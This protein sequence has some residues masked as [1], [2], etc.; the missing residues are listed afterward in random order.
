MPAAPASSSATPNA[1]PATASGTRRWR[2]RRLRPT[3]AGLTAIVCVGESAGERAAGRALAVIGRQVERSTPETATSGNTA[4]AY[5]PVWAI[6]SGRAPGLA[7]IA[8]AHAEVRAAW[9][10]R[11]SGSGAPLRVL[12][13]GSVTA[14]NAG[15]HPGR[16]GRGRCAGRRR[17][18]VCG[19]VLADLPGVP[20]SPP[21][22]SR[23]ERRWKRSFSW[24]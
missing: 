13:G 20:L 2:P 14:R 12:Y 21:W 23:E 7:D 16:A 19:R 15:R 8:A 5:E 24:S 18:P 11:F 1:A 22:G 4:I 6:G 17:Q 10:R 9:E 3:A